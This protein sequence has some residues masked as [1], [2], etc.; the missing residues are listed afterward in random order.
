[1]LTRIEICLY[2]LYILAIGVSVSSAKTSIYNF[3]CKHNILKLR[4]P[5]KRIRK[6][7]I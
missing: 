1:M 6:I 3:M 7:K 4:D 2:I 5:Y